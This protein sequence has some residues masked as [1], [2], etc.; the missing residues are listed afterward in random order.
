MASLDHSMWFY[1][2]FQVHEWLLFVVSHLIASFVCFP[3]C[4]LTSRFNLVS[5]VACVAY[6]CKPKPHPMAA[7][8]SSVEFTEKTEPW[9]LLFL[10]RA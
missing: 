8:L 9:L 5:N 10:K 6:R 3:E 2:P 1:Q 4:L 7:V